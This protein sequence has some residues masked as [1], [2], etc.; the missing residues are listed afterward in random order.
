MQPAKPMA[1]W[2]LALGF[3]ALLLPISRGADENYLGT[4]K[5]QW[6]GGGG[7]GTFDM[8]LA[9]DADGQ[10]VGSIAVGTDGGDYTARFSKLNVAGGALTASYEYP[11]DPTGEVNLNGKLELKQASGK[12]SLAAKGK[13]GQPFIDGTWTVTKP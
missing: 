1:A 6:E 5:G 12:W 10:L 8:T 11:P 7:S 3:F 9:R 2:L 13:A 4:W